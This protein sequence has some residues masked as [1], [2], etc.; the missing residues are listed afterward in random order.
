[1][2]KIKIF[3]ILILLT[4]LIPSLSF[5]NAQSVSVVPCIPEGGSLGAVVPNNN[6]KC[7]RGLTAQV[8]VGVVGTRGTCVK[9]DTEKNN[10]GQ[11]KNRG[12]NSSSTQIKPGNGLL[13]I[14]DKLLKFDRP[15]LRASTTVNRLE[16]RENNIERIR[17][18]LASTTASTSE[19]RIDKLNDRLVK[20]EEQMNKAKDRL[21]GK[22]LKIMDVLGQIASKIQARITILEGKG[23]DMTA[24]KAKLA[25]ASIKIEDMTEEGDNLTTLINTPLTATSSDQIFTDIRASQDKIRSLAI[26]TKALLIDTIK[27]IN[28]VLPEKNKATTTAT[29][30]EE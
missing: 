21:L 1:M 7:C 27:E 10:E 3:S 4:L 15:F 26:E 16:N 20:Q 24:A 14:D 9:T 11:D 13:K 2:K 23:L 8:P 29:T 17:E 19:K 12:N 6:V 18:R 5:I 30:T 28:K 25:E 22:E